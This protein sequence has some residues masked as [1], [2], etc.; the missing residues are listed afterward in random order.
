MHPS[1][2]DAGVTPAA[3]ARA[4]SPC[5]LKADGLRLRVHVTP[6]A[7]ADRI[8]EVV[9]DG[10]VARLKL[11]VTAPPHGGEANAAVTAL[12]A[13]T[14]RLP[15]SAFAVVAGAG[16]REKTIAIAGDAAVIAA[17][18]EAMLTAPEERQ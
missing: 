16:S 11:A 18:I 8:G 12:L 10:R 15:K 14:L 9:G 1:R 5:S 2:S 3:A 13:R 7:G 17:H 6:R 4:P